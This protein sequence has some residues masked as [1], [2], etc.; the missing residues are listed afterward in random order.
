[1]DEKKIKTVKIMKTFSLNKEENLY[2][3]TKIP[4]TEEFEARTVRIQT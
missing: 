4:N 2:H 1:M 3:T